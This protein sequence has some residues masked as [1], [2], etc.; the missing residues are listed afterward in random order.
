MFRVN[1]TCSCLE[2]NPTHGMERSHQRNLGKVWDGN[3]DFLHIYTARGFAEARESE[4]GDRNTLCFEDNPQTDK[5]LWGNWS[6]LLVTDDKHSIVVSNSPGDDIATLNER[7]KQTRILSRLRIHFVSLALRRATRH[8]SALE[9]FPVMEMQ[10]PLQCF[11]IVW[12]FSALQASTEHMTI[13]L[14]L[15]FGNTCWPTWDLIW[16]E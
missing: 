5:W 13:I 1:I 2:W 4:L 9:F 12:S 10:E 7:I 14:N 16:T 3:S 6:A 11:I 8:T 15:C